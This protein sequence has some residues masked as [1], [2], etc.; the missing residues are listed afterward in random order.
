ML[1]ALLVGHWTCDLQVVD[2]IY[3]SWIQVLAG[4]SCVVALDKL[5]TPLCLC[6]QAV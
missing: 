2:V 1:L 3:R 6:H 4:H 5:L